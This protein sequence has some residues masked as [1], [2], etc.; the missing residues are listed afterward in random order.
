MKLKGADIS[1]H[2]GV[3]DFFVA[4]NSGLDFVILRAS[5]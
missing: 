3:C 1:S 4:K 5:Y 2:N